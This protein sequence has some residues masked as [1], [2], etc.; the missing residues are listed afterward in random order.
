MNK[1]ISIQTP[2]PFPIEDA[3]CVDS[4]SAATDYDDIQ[5]IELICN[6]RFPIFLGFSKKNQRHIAMK[7]F[8]YNEGKPSPAYLNESRFSNL[9]HRNVIRILGSED[10]RPAVYK[11][12]FY[13]V[14]YLLMELALCDF[15]D[16]MNEVTIHE[17]EKLARTF[18]HQLIDGIDYLHSQGIA[19]MDLKTEN[20][21]F[22]QDFELKITD[23]DFSYKKGD[24][25]TVG[26][27]TAHYRA[28]EVAKKICKNPKAADLYSAGILLFIFKFGH[29]PYD[30]E[31]LV[32][33]YDLQDLLF[34][35]QEAF[36]EA[37][38][39]IKGIPLEASEDF[40]QL[41]FGLVNEDPNK[42]FSIQEVRENAWFQ[43]TIY[44]KQEINSIFN[45]AFKTK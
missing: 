38:G 14:S 32:F 20:L 28:P 11:D 3:S 4:R 29:I 15:A 30:E 37:H 19:H 7:M 27:G 44:N 33:G 42:R 31:A 45:R 12:K 16:L 23:F 40:K 10:E 6:S 24:F 1:V 39:K 18:F 13:T 26:K 8:K 34:H 41:F 43:G 2:Q 22:G 21:L 17:D 35:N 9:R 5:L 25:C 36:W